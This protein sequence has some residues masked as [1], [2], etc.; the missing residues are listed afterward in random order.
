MRP[1][2]SHLEHEGLLKSHYDN[3]LVGALINITGYTYLDPPP[4]AVKARSRFSGHAHHG[5]LG[6]SSSVLLR[7][8]GAK[9]GAEYSCSKDDNERRL[10]KWLLTMSRRWLHGA[11]PNA[12]S[13]FEET[14]Q[15][16]P[17]PNPNS[18]SYVRPGGN[19]MRICK[20][21]KVSFSVLCAPYHGTY[22]RFISHFI[23]IRGWCHSYVLCSQRPF[24]ASQ[25]P[26]VLDPT[27]WLSPCTNSDCLSSTGIIF[28]KLTLSD[29][30]LSRQARTTKTRQ[31]LLRYRPIRMTP[32]TGFFSFSYTHI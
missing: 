26:M 28:R 16:S 24:Y 23:I 30:H 22:A 25:C 29:K 32:P 15:G 10:R 12:V 21:V 13:S 1:A 27:V 11:R 6:R 14:W 5:A 7:I 4:L 2:F 3:K 9:R 17:T 31:T 20:Q 18:T 8:G 19:M